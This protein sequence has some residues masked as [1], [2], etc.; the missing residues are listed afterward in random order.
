MPSLQPSVP[1][2]QSR[3]GY[4]LLLSLILLVGAAKPILYDT[5]DPDC[6]WHLRVGQQLLRDGIHPLHD[7]LSFA[8]IREPWTPYSWLAEIAMFKLWAIGGY[9]AAILTT[10]LLIT[11]IL[12]FTAMSAREMARADE[13]RPARYLATVISVVFAAWLSLPYLSF[14][15]VTAAICCLA[16][17]VWLL[18]RDRRLGERSAAVWLLVPLTMLIINLHLFAILIPIWCGTL[19]LG[20]IIEQYPSTAAST[21]LELRRRTRRYALLT[22]L[23]LIACLFTPML[24]GLLTT[25]HHYSL[26]DPMVASS[27][28][29]EM[30]PFWHGAMGKVSLGLVLLSVGCAVR[31][32][33]AL[34]PGNVLLLIVTAVLL[35]WMGRFAPI[36]ALIAA[37]VLA[38]TLP[39][40][41]DRAICNPLLQGSMALILLCAL[42]RTFAAIPAAG[43]PVALW[44][45]RHGPDA[46]GYPVD[47]ANFIATHCPARSGRLINEF[48]W[49]G[50]LAWRLG[51]HFQVLLDGRTQLYSPEF[52][53][54]VYLG[55]QDSRRKY[56]ATAHAD[57][58]V[59]PVTKS[60]FR[61]SL[62]SLGWT[63]IYRDVRAEVLIPPADIAAIDDQ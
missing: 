29:S 33:A 45:N 30:Q 26:R 32:R 3:R 55:N 49:G 4:L 28:I 43:M 63:S 8:S 41:S 7:R 18:L 56:L 5:L 47:A 53:N 10:T 61:D 14:R 13:D 17:G 23:T 19:F 39:Q 44:I 48:T 36:Y 38:V 57:A 15:P 24:P 22:G 58:A 60:R 9:R 42:A 50:Y 2:S 6:F 20:A 40:L 62:L 1:V 12:I 31:S 35:L 52:W 37:P 34:R 46:P 27:V 51:D 59:L 16:A 11:A 54:A 21:K 25:I